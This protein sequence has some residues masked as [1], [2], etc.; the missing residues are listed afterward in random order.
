MKLLHRPVSAIATAPLIAVELGLALAAAPLFGRMAG[1]VVALFFAACGARLLMNR[2]GA[3]LPSLPLKVVCFGLGAGGIALTYGTA[4]GIEPGLSILLLL[5]SLKLLETN[6]V[7][8]FQVTAL[9]GYFLALC[10]LFFTQALTVWLYVAAIFALLTAALVHFHRGKDA[11]GFRGAARRG[12]VLLLQ[13]LPIIVLLF[14]FF[15]RSQQRFAMQFS[16]PLIGSGGMSDSLAPGSIA[17]LALGRELVFRADFPNGNAPSMSAMYW[18]AGVLWQGDGL[19][20][21]R[22]RQ[23]YPEPR[24]IPLGGAGVSQRITV[25]PHGAHWLY[26][27]DRPATKVRGAHHEVG[28]FLQSDRPVLKQMRY[29]VISRPDNRET[30]LPAD[31]RQRA[32]QKPS[33]ISPQVQALVNVWRA[34]HPGDRELVDAALHHFRNER[35]TYTLEPGTY[36]DTHALDEF[37]FERRAGFCEHYAAAFASLMRVAGI[38]SRVIIGYHGGENNARGGYVIVRQSEA[39]AW[40][41]VW[42]KGEGWERVDP[43]EMIAPDRLS[44]GLDSFLETRAAADPNA[45]QRSAAATGWRELRRELRLVWDNVNYQWDLRILGFDEES[46]RAFLADLGFGGF[47]WVEMGISVSIVI[48]LLLGGIGLWQRRPGRPPLDE[49]GRAYARF[50][51][52]LATAGLPREPWEG[53]QHFGER[54][55]TR[56]TA[57]AAA[58]R[59]ITALYARLRYAPTPPPAVE[60][61]R[62][63][64]ALPRL[65]RESKRS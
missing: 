28:G 49:T 16:Q 51:R 17:S 41:E 57:Q 59:E 19:T 39:H 33:R 1:W 13:A 12:G 2:R 48:A 46:Q 60:L 29:E 54:A 4:I 21:V 64:R 38:P 22:G 58:I 27:L 26:A 3:R 63:V 18:R 40:C 5:V 50:C 6:T 44:S 53:P 10:G 15:P 30:T 20:W 61:F 34:A 7:R 23:L 32:T 47:R 45:A 24:T 14:I 62:A 35:F 9:L 8:D 56:F 36:S 52:A 43:T 11:G 55:A 65:E 31:Q 37:L 25:Q 42:I